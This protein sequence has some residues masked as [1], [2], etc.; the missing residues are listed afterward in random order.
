MSGKMLRM[1]RRLESHGPQGGRAQRKTR[2]PSPLLLSKLRPSLSLSSLRRTGD[3]RSSTVLF[4][5]GTK[6]EGGRGCR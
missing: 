1:E 3:Q 5:D 6:G 4:S 2:S